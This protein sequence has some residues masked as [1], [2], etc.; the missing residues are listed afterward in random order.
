[1]IAA[2]VRQAMKSTISPLLLRLLLCSP[3]PSQTTKRRGT[4]RKPST[5][6]TQPQSSQPVTQ[7][8]PAG[9]PTRPPAAPVAL[10][11]VNGQTVTT[12]ELE[13]ELRQEMESLDDKIAGA[14]RSVLDLQI[15]TTLLELEAKK[16][17]IDT[18]RLYELEVSNRVP[19]FTPAQIKKFIDDNRDQFAG[20]DPN[21]VN[22]Q[23]AV[24]LH[25]D[26]ENKLADNLVNPLRQYNPG[27]MGVDI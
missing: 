5:T 24:Y 27:V 2:R 23:V 7:P 10:V 8:T 13:P 18:H 9:Q 14:R 21:V 17:R 3:A 26:A 22:Q 1:M 25:D 4:A 12:A 11:V 19:T 20:M 16:R 15:N 6:T